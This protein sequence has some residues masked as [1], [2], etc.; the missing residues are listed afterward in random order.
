MKE[1]MHPIAISPYLIYLA[2]MC[3]SCFST[4]L[5]I[6]HFLQCLSVCVDVCLI[7]GQS[8]SIIGLPCV[9]YCHILLYYCASTL[10]LGLFLLQSLYFYRYSEKLSSCH[11]FGI[12]KSLFEKVVRLG[13][14]E[15][16]PLEMRELSWYRES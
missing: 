10:A 8:K 12:W 9:Q 11:C 5:I 6:T 14:L 15:N 13:G 3:C 4:M 2:A 7:Q 1:R 16:P